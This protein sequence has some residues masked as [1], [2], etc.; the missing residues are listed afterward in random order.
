[1]SSDCF[2]RAAAIAIFIG[3]AAS[4]ALGDITIPTVPIGNAGNAPDPTTGYGSVAYTYNIGTTEVTNAQYAAFL[5]AK[6][7]ADPFNLFNPNMAGP[8]GG[9][10]R[11]GSSGSYTYATINGRENNPVNFVSFW[12]ATRFVNWLHN[13]QGQGD[14]E[15]GAYPLTST[16]ISSNTITRHSGAIWAV[17]SEDEWY[18]AAYHQP[19]SQGG[20]GDSYWLF[21]TSSNSALLADANWGN[22]VGNTS[23]VGSFAANFYG[24]FDLAGNV[25]EFNEAILGPDDAFRGMRGGSMYS[26]FFG[27]DLQ[28]DS[29]GF[30]YPTTEVEYYGFRVVQIPAPSSVALLAI[31]GVIA[32]RRRR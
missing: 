23:P 12:D 4:S 10:T 22:V 5:N 29:R 30:A 17:T 8:F 18:K 9:I 11:S 24:V 19:T 21:P 16:G 26:S 3:S 6:A 2:I 13:G 14:T 31:G 15:T 25:R 28:A 1:M 32:A 7:A 27:N 20:D